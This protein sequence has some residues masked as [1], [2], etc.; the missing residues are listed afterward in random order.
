MV[1]TISHLLDTYG[2]IHKYCN[3]VGLTDEELSQ[4]RSNLMQVTLF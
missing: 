2:S 3:K 4:I 1:A